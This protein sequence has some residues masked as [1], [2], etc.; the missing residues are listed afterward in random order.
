MLPIDEATICT[1]KELFWSIPTDFLENSGFR[2]VIN[3]MKVMIRI[4]ATIKYRNEYTICYLLM[5][6]LSVH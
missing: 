1:L 6:P 3:P 4:T 5:K 2:H